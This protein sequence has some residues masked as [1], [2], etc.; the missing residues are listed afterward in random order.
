MATL[1]RKVNASNLGRC[2]YPSR[3][4]SAACLIQ[5]LRFSVDADVVVTA[6]QQILLEHLSTKLPHHELSGGSGVVSVLTLNRPKANAMGSVM[7]QQ[8]KEYL[9]ELEELESKSRCLV[10]TSH[11]DK[12]FSAGAD[13][14]ERATMTISQAAAF[15]TDLRHTMDR[16]SRLPIPVI[17][18]I[19]G[20]AVGGGLEICLA[21]DLRIASEAASLGLPETSLA[22]VPGAGGTQRLPR[23]IGMARAKELIYTG[24]RI[25]GVTAERYGLVQHVVAPGKAKERAL[26]I[27]W[28]IAENGPVAIK[29]AKFAMDEGL[30]AKNMMEAL[31]IERQAYERVL[32]TRDRLEGLNAF[33]EQRKPDYRGE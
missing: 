25:D 5:R 8:L 23:L 10:L 32:T 24:A 14:K 22:I 16:L 29:A 27:A 4:A 9:T 21:A 6:P 26:E 1:L 19:E 7:L 15:V 17:A 13:L 30:T 11:S 2:C 12:V 33:K 18:A 31:A 28:K 20:V 3:A